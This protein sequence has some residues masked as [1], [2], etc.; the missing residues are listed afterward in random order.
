MGQIMSL[1]PQI[2]KADLP[3]GMVLVLVLIAMLDLRARDLRWS[4]AVGVVHL[5][6]ILGFGMRARSGT[7]GP[8]AFEE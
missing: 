5:A 1:Q 2:T 6:A 8:V 4:A 3:P 7:G